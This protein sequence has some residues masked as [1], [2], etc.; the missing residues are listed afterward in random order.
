MAKNRVF[1]SRDIKFRAPSGFLRLLGG[2]AAYK[3]F[4][5]RAN[6]LPAAALLV[7][8]IIISEAATHFSTQLL[9]Q[10]HVAAA[11]AAPVASLVVSGGKH[12]AWRLFIA[13]CQALRAAHSAA[14]HFSRPLAKR[15]PLRRHACLATS[16]VIYSCISGE[17]GSGSGS[18][19]PQPVRCLLWLLHVAAAAAAAAPSTSHESRRATTLEIEAICLLLSRILRVIKK[20]AR[21][22]WHRHDYH[23][24]CHGHFCSVLA[25][26]EKKKYRQTGHCSGNLWQLHAEPFT[27]R[28]KGIYL[29]R[30]W[31]GL[32]WLG[33]FHL[34]ATNRICINQQGRKRKR[35]Q[36]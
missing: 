25:I 33:G 9:P 32:A 18:D 1:F 12:L 11:A 30:S 2:A 28:L 4:K 24:H 36:K 16:R 34:A 14:A 21:T 10:Q 35:Y 29:R 23:Y 8:I 20:G 15:V 17:G 7:I 31:L 22:P 13:C 19:G 26:E 6:H 5:T 27:F 3:Q